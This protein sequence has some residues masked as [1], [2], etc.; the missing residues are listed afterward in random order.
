MC[1]LTLWGTSSYRILRINFHRISHIHCHQRMCSRNMLE[2]CFYWDEIVVNVLV[3]VKCRLNF[4]NNGLDPGQKCRYFGKN[5]WLCGCITLVLLT[6]GNNA[7]CS[8]ST[9]QST[10]RV[11]LLTTHKWITLLSSLYLLWFIIQ[12]WVNTIIQTDHINHPVFSHTLQVPPGWTAHIILGVRRFLAFLFG[13]NS[14][15]GLQKTL[16]N[17]FG[18]SCSPPASYTADRVGLDVLVCFRDGDPVN[19]LALFGFST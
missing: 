3:F 2:K 13:H 1:R 15:F 17:R 12:C 7:H 6:E 16:A 5:L 9:H 19:S 18:G 10:S 4:P 11:S 8:I 14:N